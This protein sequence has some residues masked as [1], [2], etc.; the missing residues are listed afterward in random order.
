MTYK[1][2]NHKIHTCCIN[3]QTILKHHG[4]NLGPVKADGKLPIN[5]NSDRISSIVP[6]H[7]AEKCREKALKYKA[8]TI[9]KIALIT[10]SDAFDLPCNFCPSLWYANK[11]KVQCLDSWFISACHTD[12]DHALPFPLFHAQQN[13]TQQLLHQSRFN[14]AGKDSPH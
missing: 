10:T 9:N 1:P 2:R 4:W 7:K 12:L 3:T 6:T 8:K 11:L 14:S 13:T 5:F